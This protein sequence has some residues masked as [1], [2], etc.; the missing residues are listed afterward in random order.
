MKNGVICEPIEV[1]PH[2]VV[3]VEHISDNAEALPVEP[4]PHFHEVCELVY[5]RKASGS[6]ETNVGRLKI[7][8]HMVAFLPSMQVHE[9]VI[10]GGAREWILLHIDPALVEDLA[11]RVGLAPLKSVICR[12]AT[13]TDQQRINT[14][15]DWLLALSSEPDP[16]QPTVVRIV[17]LLMLML[18]SWGPTVVDHALSQP[19]MF[20]RLQPALRL[21][22][23]HPGEVVTLENA[24]TACNLSPAYFSRQ[25][26][27]VFGTAFNEYARG[28]RLRLAARRII[29]GGE[30]I[31]HIAHELGFGTHAHFSAAFNKRYGMTPRE[32][33]DRARTD[34]AESTKTR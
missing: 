1:L 14:L 21:V 28:F 10:E 8:P 17:E 2:N 18:S 4:F 31:S 29:A 34:P 6:L 23:D 20:E 7:E 5:F 27:Q 13:A 15:L 12:L 9:F 26:K 24:A 32:Y 30:R 16:D 22:A 11:V 3:H 19:A 25:F 33:R